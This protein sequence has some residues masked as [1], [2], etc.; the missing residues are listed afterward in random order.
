MSDVEKKTRHHQKS[1]FKLPTKR[2]KDI[3]S[4]MAKCYLYIYILYM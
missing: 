4:N 2:T 1:R 3:R